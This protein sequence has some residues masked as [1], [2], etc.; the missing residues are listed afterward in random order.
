[1]NKNLLNDG[2]KNSI[3]F[4]III[5]FISGFFIRDAT[6]MGAKEKNVLSRKTKEMF[7]H[8]Y[9][10]YMS[11]AFPADELMPLSCKGRYRDD[12]PSLSDPLSE[13]PQVQWDY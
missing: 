9:S 5:L 6:S 8:A 12:G 7:Y 11:N 1:M 4:L 3:F 13:S 2:L 10:S